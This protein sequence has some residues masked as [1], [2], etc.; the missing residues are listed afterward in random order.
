VQDQ[1]TLGDRPIVDSADGQETP[2]VLSIVMPAYNE[3]RTIVSAVRHVLSTAFPCDFE[4]IVVDDGSS[5]ET[6]ER[7]ITLTHERLRVAQ[8]SE[9]FGK[10]AALRTGISLATGTHLIPFDADLEYSAADVA[11][12]VL[13]VVE[14]RTEVV[15]GARLFGF[16]TV[17][18]SFRYKLGNKFTTLMANLLFDSAITDMHTCLKLIPLPLLRQMRLTERGFGLDTE[19]T[20]NMLRMGYR[21]FE[22]PVSYY[23]RS[24][25]QGKKINWKDGVHCLRVLG[26]VRL[27]NLKA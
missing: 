11:R 26:K 19:I 12:M 10:G 13:H 14:G 23:A 5:D 22:V 21:P 6:A 16:N 9:N 3:G 25:V 24:H 17:Y 18:R 2:V 27:R 4:L 7:L 15:Y 8:H 20:A 1:L